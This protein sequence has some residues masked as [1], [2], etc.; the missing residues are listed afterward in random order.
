MKEQILET[1]GKR[2]GL[3]GM[4]LPNLIKETTE[5]NAGMVQVFYE[6]KKRG[7]GKVK[8]NK[9]CIVCSTKVA[10]EAIEGGDRHDLPNGLTVIFE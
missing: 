3:M 2:M 6:T 4:E 9:Y 1:V 10:D 5:V 7:R 8:G